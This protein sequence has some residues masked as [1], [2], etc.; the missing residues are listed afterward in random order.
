MLPS[1]GQIPQVPDASNVAYSAMNAAN[2]PLP[3]FTL[4][5]LEIYPTYWQAVTIV[6][7]LFLLV[8]TLARMRYLYVHW[9]LSKTSLAMLFW[10]FLL[11]V[12][13]EAFLWLSGRTVLTTVLGWKN[14]PK[15]IAATLDTGREKLVKVLGDEVE[16]D[17]AKAEEPPS[18]QSVVFD[19]KELSDQDKVTVQKFVCEP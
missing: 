2:T 16:V 10:G 4:W 12:I 5:G 14:P 1:N 19:Y 17:N 8:F 15:P 3:S 6:I 7:L 13:L 9:H 11:T 18:Y